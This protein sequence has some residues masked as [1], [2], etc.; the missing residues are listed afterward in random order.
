MWIEQE[1]WQKLTTG[2]ATQVLIEPV[3]ILEAERAVFQPEGEEQ[4]AHAHVAAAEASLKKK[5]MCLGLQQHL[6]LNGA[7]YWRR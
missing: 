3:T 1:I 7:S 4:P 5:A 2:Q 6:I